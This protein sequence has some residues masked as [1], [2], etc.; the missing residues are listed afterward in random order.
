M[1]LTPYQIVVPIVCIIL[2]VYAW[3]LALRKKK[4]ILETLFW[5]MFWGLIAVIA[6]WPHVASYLSVLTG[7]ADQ[8][9]AASVTFIGILFFMVF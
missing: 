9:N 2:I 6:F 1:P 8:E 7:I 3:N 5:T 4:T